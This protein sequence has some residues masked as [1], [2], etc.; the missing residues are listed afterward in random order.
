MLQIRP[1]LVANPATIAKVAEDFERLAGMP[2]EKGIEKHYSGDVK[3]LLMAVAGLGK[4]KH[5]VFADQIYNATKVVLH[6]NNKKM[7]ILGNGNEG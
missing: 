1:L 5:R 4:G 7:R 2:F 6:L 3:N